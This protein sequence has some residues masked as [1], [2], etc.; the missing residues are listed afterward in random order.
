M[1][2]IVLTIKTSMVELSLEPVQRYIILN[3][4]WTTKKRLQ[5][6]LAKHY[7]KLVYLNFK[8]IAILTESNDK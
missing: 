5:D 3:E 1:I 6:Y 7:T 8:N 4:S 2:N